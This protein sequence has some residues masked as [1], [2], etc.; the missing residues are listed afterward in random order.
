MDFKP[1]ENRKNIWI[2]LSGGT[3]SALLFYTIVQYLLMNKKQTI[4]TPYCLVDKSRPGN[5]LD[6]R[7]IINFVKSK[8]PYKYIDTIVTGEFDKPPA[9]DKVALTEPFWYAMKDSGKYDLYVSGLT[10]S[11]SVDEMKSIDGFYEAFVKLTSE[12]RDPANYKEEFKHVD[13]LDIW[14][15][16]INIDKKQIAKW[17]EDFDLM[18]NLFP[19]TKSCVDR[20]YTPCMKC[21]WCYEKHWAFGLFDMSGGKVTPSF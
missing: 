8:L 20:E 1:L 3:D 11:P 4:V 16:F 9:A 18:D 13:G 7:H 10:A 2:S 19:L 6:A 14:N 5:D 17:Y 15:P 12:D 21:Y